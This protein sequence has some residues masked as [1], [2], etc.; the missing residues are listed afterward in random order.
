MTPRARNRLL[1]VLIALLFLLPF[2]IAAVLR[3]GGWQP[4]QTRNIGTLLQPPVAVGEVPATRPDGSP[5]PW[6]NMEHEWTLLVQLPAECDAPCRQ[7]LAVL[8]NVQA[9]LGRH[10]DRLHPFVFGGPLEA[11][12]FPRLAFDAA[13]IAPLAGPLPAQPQAW[14]V[15]PHGFV[16]LHYPPGFDPAGLR[17]DLSRLLK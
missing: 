6:I 5:W 13:R 2:G 14:L 15:D 16:V 9:A 17:R 1:L 8:P 7:H 11:A 4:P 3:F 10:A 12:P